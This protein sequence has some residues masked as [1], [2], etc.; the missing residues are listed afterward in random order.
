V[1]R[2]PFAVRSTNRKLAARVG[3]PQPVEIAFAPC[4]QLADEESQTVLTTQLSLLLFAYGLGCL[5][6]GYYLLRWR[7][8][9][10]IR[11]LGSGNAGARNVGRV[12]G[13]KGFVLVFALDAAKG[14]VAVTAAHQWAPEVAALSAVVVTLGHVYPAQLSLRGGKGVATAI[15]ALAALVSGSRPIDTTLAALILAAL[16]TFTHRRRR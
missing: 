16:L 6:A 7:D 2:Y 10:D 3:H 1:Q 9:R 13:R 5:N 8:G 11:Q 4:S 12:L 14:V 15:G